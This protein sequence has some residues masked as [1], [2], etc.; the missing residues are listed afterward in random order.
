M[1]RKYENIQNYYKHKEKYTN[2]LKRK[3]N[4]LENAEEYRKERKL[5]EIIQI[6]E[7]LVHIGYILPSFHPFFNASLSAASS[8][9]RFRPQPSQGA[10]TLRTSQPSRSALLWQPC[11]TKHQR[12]KN[13]H[14]GD[15]PSRVRVYIYIYICI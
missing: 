2:I 8:T 7:C 1:Y 12:P 14:D 13:G 9:F 15:R 11:Y 4:L 6:S 10:H 5:S 3:E